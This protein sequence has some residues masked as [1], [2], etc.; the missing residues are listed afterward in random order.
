M[1]N[2]WLTYLQNDGAVVEN[3]VVA[4]FGNLNAE[5]YAALDGNVVADLSNFALLR[6]SGDDG[7]AFLHGQ[8]SN[9]VEKLGSDRVQYTSYN[10]P[11][12]RMIA[13]M[14]LWRDGADYLMMVPA[15]LRD[16]VQ[17]R[18]SMFV[19]RA[20]VKV[21]D[22][23][24]EFVLLG[25]AGGQSTQILQDVVGAV[26]DGPMRT[27][28]ND[29]A[30][31][32]RLE[33]QKFLVVAK[34][35][36]QPLWD[37]LKKRLQP[38]GMRAWSLLDIRSGIAWITPNTQEQFVAQMTNYELIGGVDFKKGCYPG[39]EIVARTQYLGRLKRR[40]Y[41]V[42]VDT[43]ELASGDELFSKDFEDQASGMVVNAAPS[44]LGGYDAL[45]VIQIDSAATQTVHARSIDGPALTMLDLPYPIK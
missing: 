28:K 20:K 41:L 39:Q 3:G 34:P 24:G 18:L 22:A 38:I 42:H 16:V 26:P 21:T 25:I 11:K 30:Q 1:K 12:G 33:A 32:I 45:A 35:P 43:V 27:S 6:F 23:S 19:M 44:P 8:L 37:R 40:M 7:Q 29:V 17:K 36:V 14:L 2:E 5:L 15:A 10:S 9:S 13:S 31:L 4:Q